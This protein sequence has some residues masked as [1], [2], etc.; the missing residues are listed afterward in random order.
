MIRGLYVV[1]ILIGFTISCVRSGNQSDETSETASSDAASNAAGLTKQPYTWARLTDHAGYSK[2]YNYQLL[3]KDNKLYA[4]H[5]DG[6]WQSSNGASWTKT[7]LENILKNQAFLD[8]IEFKGAIYAIGTFSGSIS[9]HILTTQVARTIDME[10]WEVLATQS[11]LPKRFFYHPFVFQDKI[12]I[13]GGNDGSTVYNDAWVSVDGINWQ[14]VADDLPFGARHSQYFVIFKDQIYMLSHDVWRSKNG[15]DWEE[16]TA[17]MTPGSIVGYTPVV[18]DDK[19]WLIGNNR[20][21]S[22]SSEVW[23]SEDGLKWEKQKTPWSARVAVATCVFNNEI[24][25]T[26]GKY[27]GSNTIAADLNYNNDVWVMRKN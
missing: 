10:K 20:G 26:G 25:M 8:Y 24:I 6:V 22:M 5:P 23:Y 16:V 11:K 13:I 18:F 2:T 9:D 4:F 19:I 17:E 1:F 27:E 14:K 12:W 7:G 21:N 3:T 15:L